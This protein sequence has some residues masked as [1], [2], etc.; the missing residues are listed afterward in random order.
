LLNI[1]KIQ[2]EDQANEKTYPRTRLL[3]EYVSTLTDK[4]QKMIKADQFAIAIQLLDEINWVVNRFGYVL[5]NETVSFIQNLR[6]KVGN[7]ACFEKHRQYQ[8]FILTAE[9][10]MSRNDYRHAKISL[11][12]AK[13]YVSNN[14]EC[15]FDLAQIK[16]TLLRIEQP[17]LYQKMVEDIKQQAVDNKFEEALS[18][19]QNILNSVSDSVLSKFNIPLKKIDEIAIDVNYMPFIHY[20]ATNLAQ[21][22]YPN[23][24]FGLITILYDSKYNRELTE[25]A[26]AEL[27][28]SLAKEFFIKDP[29][30][31]S[32]QLYLGYTLDKKWSKPFIN[33]YKKKWKEMQ[34]VAE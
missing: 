19:Y 20:V 30:V 26:Q 11:E 1:R 2:G 10:F 4:A 28:A 7:Q 6:S 23:R 33:A 31:E 24:S 14:A 34:I 22:G 27:G 17:A 16:N 9:K 18:T 25:E 21:N 15:G 13:K 12:K 32:S 5:S 29:S 8:I 3:T